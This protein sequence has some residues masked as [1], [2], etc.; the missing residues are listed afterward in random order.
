MDSW[1][2]EVPYILDYGNMRRVQWNRVQH[3]SDAGNIILASYTA[4]WLELLEGFID[5][6]YL[7]LY[8]TIYTTPNDT[9]AAD[10]DNGYTA[11][12]VS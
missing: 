8:E 10:T 6:L 11:S 9:T 4:I 1:L 7:K 12:S 5:T 2:P 3:T